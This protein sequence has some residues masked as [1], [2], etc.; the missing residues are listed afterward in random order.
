MRQTGFLAATAAYALTHNFPK[1]AAVHQLA[2]KLEHGLLEI[3]ID[4][5]KGAETCMV[6]LDP[7]DQMHN[8]LSMARKQGLV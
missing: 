7:S 8:C 5:I 3:G 4:I 6:R 2:R 1:L